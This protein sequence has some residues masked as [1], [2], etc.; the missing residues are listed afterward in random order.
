MT[1]H[2]KTSTGSGLLIGMVSGLLL[3]SPV[4]SVLADAP[5]DQ[6][7]QGAVSDGGLDEWQPRAESGEVFAKYVVGYMFANGEN[8]PQD[9]SQALKWHTRASERGF[10]PST[11][12]VAN[13]YLDGDGVE[14]NLSKAIE[15][16][17]QAAATGYVRAQSNLAGIYLGSEDVQPDFARAIHWYRQAA[18]QGHAS[19]RYNLALMYSSGW[20]VPERDYVAA[21]ALMAPLAEQDHAGAQGAMSQLRDLMSEEDYQQALALS[22]RWRDDAQLTRMLEQYAQVSSR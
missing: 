9:P 16:Y 5:A 19:S 4:T 6:A 3:L 15:W 20:G 8:A 14:K 7:L 11:L 12:A 21:Y 22:D 13:M 1:L 2:Q 10:A 17:E 18:A